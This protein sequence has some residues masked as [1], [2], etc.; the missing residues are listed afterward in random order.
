[1][2]NIAVDY[3]LKELPLTA[4]ACHSLDVLHMGEVQMRCVIGAFRPDIAVAL[5]FRVRD[6]TPFADGN[7]KAKKR[8]I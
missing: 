3:H 1:M 6:G 5:R 4:P 7:S 2:K 8:R